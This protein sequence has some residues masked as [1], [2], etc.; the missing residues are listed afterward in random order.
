[1][2][3]PAAS[4]LSVFDLSEAIL[5]PGVLSVR[6]VP[7]HRL[8]LDPDTRRGRSARRPGVRA[9][10]ERPQRGTESRHLEPCGQTKTP[11]KKSNKR[12]IY[13]F[14]WF[15]SQLALNLFVVVTIFSPSAPGGS[16][17]WP[18]GGAAP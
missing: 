2:T 10:G 7:P 11:S 8:G 1:M 9:G 14:C 12:R 4:H 6:A 13:W 17:H 15:Y 18:L 16:S 3:P 5:E